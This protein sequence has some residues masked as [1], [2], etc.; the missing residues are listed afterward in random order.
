[1]K[2]ILTIVLM[3]ALWS[4][5][6]AAYYTFSPHGQF[7]YNNIRTVPDSA[8]LI[9]WTIPD[10]FY[11]ASVS[12]LGGG[13]VR[14][15]TTLAN[16]GWHQLT[17]VYFYLSGAIIVGDDKD[18]E[19]K[20]TL[21]WVQVIAA[22]KTGFSLAG[23]QTFNNTGT[24]AGNITGNLSGSV[25]SVTAA[26][27]VGTINSGTIDSADFAA[28]GISL[29]RRVDLGYTT[30][31]LDSGEVSADYKKMIALRADSGRSI[32]TVEVDTAAIARSVFD[33]D[34]N[35]V[36]NRT[37]GAA[38]SVTGNVSGSVGSVVSA[39]T[40]GAMNSNT[41]DSSD[42]S[43][44]AKKMIALRS[45][46]GNAPT[47]I[48]DYNLVASTA[49]DYFTFSNREDPFKGG[50]GAGPDTTDI[51]VLSA[52]DS[53]P[54]VGA[55]VSYFVGA[56][57]LATSTDSLGKATF[58]ATAGTWAAI[59]EAKPRY[60]TT[61]YIAAGGAGTIYMT[62]PTLPD[63]VDTNLTG[64][65][66]YLYSLTG[67]PLAGVVV[68]ARNQGSN[69]RVGN[70]IVSQYEVFDT[71]DAAGYWTLPLYPTAT[72]GGDAYK[73]TFKQYRSQQSIIT[74][75]NIVVPDSASWLFT[76]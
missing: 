10:T 7:N 56:T 8:W 67:D 20:D 14:V 63:P 47:A 50:A 19:V 66:G 30:G 76:W 34:I 33:A 2:R 71:T 65:Y 61:A 24:W 46:S 59:A 53:T 38:A 17:W 42:F 54:I 22:G 15:S 32:G 49:Y 28:T 29:V 69:I 41:I 6:F 4:S 55:S 5:G 21:E 48:I 31:S 62:Q 74:K 40:V 75:T 37:T 72:L 25:G 73:Y 1:M 44:D 11:N 57:K 23:T 9:D 58:G 45:D 36:A 68:S 18:Y 43:A 3:L 39:V 27:T 13:A 52:N 26:T 60:T 51:Y 12:H 64:A 35:P 70:V 16:R